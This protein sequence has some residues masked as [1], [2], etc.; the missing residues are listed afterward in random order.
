[1]QREYLQDTTSKTLYSFPFPC[2]LSCWYY[3]QETGEVLLLLK[4]PLQASCSSSPDCAVSIGSEKRENISAVHKSIYGNGCQNVEQQAA[5]YNYQ[6][7]IPC[8]LSVIGWLWTRKSVTFL[9]ELRKLAL[10]NSVHELLYT[11]PYSVHKFMLS[12]I[13]SAF[14]HSLKKEKNYFAD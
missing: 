8:W 4:N 6:E 7:K 11:S 12:C 2:I 14:G 1:M 3:W 5:T 10:L 9:P 13:I